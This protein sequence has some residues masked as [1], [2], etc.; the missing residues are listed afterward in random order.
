METP[1]GKSKPVT[2]YKNVFK[3]ITE[4]LVD[5][6]G[7]IPKSAGLSV[8]VQGLSSALDSRLEFGL[9]TQSELRLRVSNN[10]WAH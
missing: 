9:E 1:E 3:Q 5:T 4:N 2:I 10:Y 6:S 7:A 8:A